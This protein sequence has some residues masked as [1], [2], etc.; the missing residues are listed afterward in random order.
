MVGVSVMGDTAVEVLIGPGVS[1][2]GSV[3]RGVSVLGGGLVFV[4]DGGGLVFAGRCVGVMV[5]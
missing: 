2:G 5:G 4:A 3:G 1:D